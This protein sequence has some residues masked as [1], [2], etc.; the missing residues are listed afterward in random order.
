MAFLPYICFL[1]T[2]HP[3]GL[4][5]LM[6]PFLSKVLHISPVPMTPCPV[7]LD[8]ALRQCSQSGSSL[9]QVT[10]LVNEGAKVCIRVCWFSS[11]RLSLHSLSPHNS[12]RVTIKRACPDH[13]LFPAWAGLQHVQ[14]LGLQPR[15]NFKTGSHRC[16]SNGKKNRS[17]MIFVF[18]I[19]ARILTLNV[20][21][22]NISF[23]LG[24][25]NSYK[26]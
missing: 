19:R 23:L 18:A 10:E 4:C 25:L 3:P 15:R 21:I 6:P 17:Q 1:S 14:P 5:A 20:V 7:T 2:T 24:N 26:Q 11:P 16:S 13:S 9:P 12:G 8:T 22:L